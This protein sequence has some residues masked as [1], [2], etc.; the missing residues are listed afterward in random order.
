MAGILDK[1]P[2]S[3]HDSEG[4]AHGGRG[5]FVGSKVAGKVGG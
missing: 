1:G 3:S 5:L 2:A 4:H